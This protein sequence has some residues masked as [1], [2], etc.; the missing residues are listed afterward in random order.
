MGSAR[1]SVGRMSGSGGA[2]GSPTKDAYASELGESL[3]WELPLLLENSGVLED[4]EDRAVPGVVS[5]RRQVNKELMVRVKSEEHRKPQISNFGGAKV[6]VYDRLA[7]QKRD[8]KPAERVT[9][10]IQS[11]ILGA[12]NVASKLKVH[13]VEKEASV[14]KVASELTKMKLDESSVRN[15]AKD[16]IARVDQ[17]EWEIAR[18]EAKAVDQLEYRLTLEQMEQR[19]RW[20]GETFDAVLQDLADRITV[21]DERIFKVSNAAEVR[22]RRGAQAAF[23]T[24]HA[25]KEVKERLKKARLTARAEIAHQKKMQ[26][27]EMIRVQAVY[28]AKMRQF[29][30]S[31]GSDMAGRLIRL[32]SE[33]NSLHSEDNEIGQRFA[34]NVENA[35]KLVRGLEVCQFDPEDMQ[36]G[37][38]EAFI[39]KYD[40]LISHNVTLVSYADRLTTQ[41]EEMLTEKQKFESM[42]DDVALNEEAGEG[43]DAAP[44]FARKVDAAE[45]K[46]KIAESR[47]RKAIESADEMGRYVLDARMGLIQ[48]AQRVNSAMNK[49]HNL[50]FPTKAAVP[51]EARPKKGTSSPSPNNSV[52][53]MS[54]PLARRQSAVENA[55]V[56]KAEESLSHVAPF[57]SRRLSLADWLQLSA[58]EKIAGAS[59]REK[60]LDLDNEPNTRL[61][62]LNPEEAL[63]LFE[64]EALR[65]VAGEKT[66]AF[67]ELE[68]QSMDRISFLIS[69]SRPSSALTARSQGGSRSSSPKPST[70][71][72]NTSPVLKEASDSSLGSMRPADLDGDFMSDSSDSIASRS[73]VKRTSDKKY[74]AATTI[75]NE[76]YYRRLQREQE[77]LFARLS[78]K[79]GKNR[80]IPE[81]RVKP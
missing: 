13:E 21:Q 26:G 66:K 11:K 57:H 47:V 27:D 16:L 36:V 61:S 75:R 8:V 7:H 18:R 53:S 43:K 20:E 32:G 68:G 24:S 50:G 39:D 17:L 33:R 49:V 81:L 12:K 14:A 67:V 63:Q 38:A 78:A 62:E 35:R 77:E 30:M 5:A 60:E 15:D 10:N 4:E 44:T 42:R 73:G 46:L 3:E 58:D 19:M 31:V 71:R 54:R 28:E 64:R 59:E 34:D 40:K 45:R 1:A 55:R 51:E 80:R 65:V 70:L 37:D 22:K 9:R 25:V 76:P 79:G 48:V 72:P 41:R 69:E 6:D 74:K 56:D 2:A 29:A 23:E 52:S